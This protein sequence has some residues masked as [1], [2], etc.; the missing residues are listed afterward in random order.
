[1]TKK[2]VGRRAIPGLTLPGR[3]INIVDTLFPKANKIVWP[4]FGGTCKVPKISR[5]EIIES[6]S[7]IPL[8][9]APGLGGVPDMVVKEVATRKPDIILSDLFN[10]CLE[11]GVFPE[12]WKTAELVL[13]RKGAKPLDSPSSNRPICLL[14]SVGKLFERIIKI[15]LENHLAETRGLNEKQY[16]FRKGRSTVDAVNKLME[17]VDKSSSGPLR[18]RQLCAVVA[19]DV[20]NAFNTARWDKIKQGLHQKTAPNYLIKIIQSYLSHRYLQH[21]KDVSRTVT[22]GVPQGSVIGPLLWNLIYDGLLNVDT[23]GNME[24]SSTTM[25]AFAD[26]VAVITTGRTTVILEEVTN[27]ALEVVAD[28]MEDIVWSYQYRNG[29]NRPYQ[30]ERILAVKL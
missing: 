3:L 18:K 19:L 13:L 16:G 5:E 2:L 24:R 15:R 27:R 29:S 12:N 7:R 23:E 9:K 1:M 22:C 4:P 21:G 6:S 25:V 28:C 14:N 11:Q 26:D 20:N 8:G 30:Q 10:V 17:T